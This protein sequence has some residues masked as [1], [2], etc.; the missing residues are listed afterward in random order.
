MHNHGQKQK[1][2]KMK[3]Q[4]SIRNTLFFGHP[5]LQPLGSLSHVAVSENSSKNTRK[6]NLEAVLNKN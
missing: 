1:L 4:D 2:K 3:V 6:M 5:M